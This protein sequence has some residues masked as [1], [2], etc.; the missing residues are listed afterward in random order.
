MALVA[1]QSDAGLDS[2]RCV[3]LAVAHDLAEALAGDITPHDGVGK[4]DKHRLEA[5]ALGTML[6]TLGTAPAAEHLR[7]L[8]EEYEE[9]STAEAKL[10]KDLDKV[11]MLVQAHEYEHEQGIALDEFFDST[12]GRMKTDVGKALAE[13]AARR[14][15]ER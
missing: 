7:G 11:E 5:D 4:E 9:G 10:L 15:P 12:M 6:G 2:S 1:S 13:E 8:W 14:R 3:Q